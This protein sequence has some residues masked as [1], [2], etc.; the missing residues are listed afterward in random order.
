MN[1]KG[2]IL[3]EYEKEACQYQ[4]RR[5]PEEMTLNCSQEDLPSYNERKIKNKTMIFIK[6][7]HIMNPESFLIGLICGSSYSQG[8]YMMTLIEDKD[9]QMLRVGISNM[10]NKSVLS[11][12]SFLIILAPPISQP[13]YYIDRQSS[14]DVIYLTSP[15]QAMII[16][17]NMDE[18]KHKLI[19]N[20]Y[21]ITIVSMRLLSRS[22]TKESKQ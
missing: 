11:K 21:I 5:N 9:S 15:S 16:N 14:C 7:M 13:H 10:R 1:M 6:N 12:G 4:Q 22:M 2:K 19:G 3:K 17:D 18:N 20:I 8:S